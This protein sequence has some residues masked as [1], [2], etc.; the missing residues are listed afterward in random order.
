MIANPPFRTPMLTT[1]GLVGDGWLKWILALLHA[2]NATDQQVGSV[3]LTAQTASIPGT[4]IPAPTLTAG[5]YLVR[6]YFRVTTPGTVSSSLQV[7]I[8]WTDGGVACAVSG[9]AETGNT[10]ATVQS[11]SLLVRIDAA[12]SIL[13][14]TTYASA[15]ATDMQY[16]LDV[17]LEAVP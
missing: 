3:S 13:Y 14:A 8:G 16:A 15:G 4:A 17:E 11:G 6:W 9:A 1:G 2:V 12:T 5:R 7:S 10:T